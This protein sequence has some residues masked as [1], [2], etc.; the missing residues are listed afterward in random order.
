MSSLRLPIFPLGLVLFPGLS[1]PLHL[2]EAR[3]RQLIADIGTTGRFGIVCS[4]PGVSERELPFGHAGCIAEV[5]EVEALPDGRSNIVVT[6]RER[7]TLEQ[8]VN[9]PAPYHI[10]DVLPFSD[11]PGPAPVALVVAAGE[12]IARFTRVISALRTLWECVIHQR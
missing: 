6:G 10:A 9:D 11:L 12:V 5:R 3:Y 1:L 7:F 8:F 2:F 4:I